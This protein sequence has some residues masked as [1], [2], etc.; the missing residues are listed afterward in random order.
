MTDKDKHDL[1]T[2]LEKF[3]NSEP[4]EQVHDKGYFDNATMAGTALY[5]GSLAAAKAITALRE[6]S[7]P[8]PIAARRESEILHGKSLMEYWQERAEKAEAE[9]EKWKQVRIDKDVEIGLKMGEVERLTAK[10]EAYDSLLSDIAGRL[11]PEVLT[12]VIRFRKRIEG[13]EE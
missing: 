2:A 11:G 4:V 3:V 12:E 10:V 8:N 9:N 13:D 6:Q 1:I 7:L 5:A